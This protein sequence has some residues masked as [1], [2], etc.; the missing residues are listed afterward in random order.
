MK[1]YLSICILFSINQISAQ[2]KIKGTINTQPSIDTNLL[3]RGIQ[4]KVTVVQIMPDALAGKKDSLSL[5]GNNKIG[6]DLYQSNTD[7]MTVLIPD[8]D[9][10]TRLGY[11]LQQKESAKNKGFNIQEIIKNKGLKLPP[12]NQYRNY[13]DSS[14]KSNWYNQ[15]KPLPTR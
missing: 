10:K 8:A 14:A 3:I 7:N 1:W 4:P 11:P 15:F 2:N 13:K 9:N 6:F 12:A 5:K